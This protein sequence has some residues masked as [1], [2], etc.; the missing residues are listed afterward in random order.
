MTFWLRE[1]AAHHKDSLVV[2]ADHFDDMETPVGVARR[3][4]VLANARIHGQLA[5]KLR[6]LPHFTLPALMQ[7]LNDATTADSGTSVVDTGFN[8]VYVDADH[9]ARGTLL[10]ALLAWRLLRPG[11]YMLFDDYEWP[12]QSRKYPHNPPSLDHPDHPSSGIDAFLSLAGHELEIVSKSYQ[13]LVRKSETCAGVNVGFPLTSATAVLPVVIVL[14]Q[15]TAEAGLAALAALNEEAAAAGRQLEIVVLVEAITGDQLQQSIRESQR[16]L[17][18]RITWVKLDVGKLIGLDGAMRRIYL[19]LH[20][21]QVC[22]GRYEHA[23]MVVPETGRAAG[24]AKAA[25]QL[26]RQRPV[27][28]TVAIAPSVLPCVAVLR[29]HKLGDAHAASLTLRYELLDAEREHGWLG[30]LQRVLPA[31]ECQ[32]VTLQ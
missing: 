11:G 31:G 14:D 7:L 16:P 32:E 27:E 17:G 21:G 15:E 24:W 4:R 25:V 19:A 26:W 23:L 8:L 6:L 12:V 30:L 1:L 9:T 13:L 2:C 29:P 5:N 22:P 28:A 10:D 20:V 3:Q 18:A